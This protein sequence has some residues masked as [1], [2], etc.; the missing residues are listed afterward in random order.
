MESRPDRG[1]RIADKRHPVFDGMGAF[2]NGG[3]WNSA[4]RRVIYLADSFAAAIL[5]MLIHTRI[6]KIPRTHCWIEVRIPPG[7]SIERLSAAHLPEWNLPA[8]PAAQRFGDRWYDERR[9]LILVVPCAATGGITNN[10]LVN[11]EHTDFA[12]LHAGKPR[13]VKWDARLFER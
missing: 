12:R 4:G 2:L 6:G 11:Q 1:F 13:P 7:V 8:S 10:L 5:E 9:S 3:R